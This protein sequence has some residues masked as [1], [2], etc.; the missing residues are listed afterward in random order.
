M[1]LGYHLRREEAT[2]SG[3]PRQSTAGNPLFPLQKSHEETLN[4][5]KAGKR[6]AAFGEFHFRPRSWPCRPASL[7][8][9]FHRPSLFV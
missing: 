8:G 9:I 4:P 2:Q 1:G 7:T 5:P 3:Q 6:L